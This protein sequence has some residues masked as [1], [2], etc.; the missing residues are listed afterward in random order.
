MREAPSE[1]ESSPVVDRSA[2]LKRLTSQTH[3]GF[4][5]W[6]LVGYISI[7]AF[8]APGAKVDWLAWL[9]MGPIWFYPVIAIV[10][11]IAWRLLDRFGDKRVALVLA[12]I[13]A[14][15]SI[16]MFSLPVTFCLVGFCF[17]E[18]SFFLPLALGGAILVSYAYLFEM[19]L[20][21]RQ[22]KIRFSGLVPRLSITN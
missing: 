13:P 14:A 6:F 19:V 17:G 18:V 11:G 8:G 7:M 22:V 3:V 9:T 2:V 15:I 10:C 1:T 20:K 12:T 5:P 21:N 4:F 16:Y